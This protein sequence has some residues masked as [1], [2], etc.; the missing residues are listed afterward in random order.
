MEVESPQG[1]L[2]VM[3]KKTVRVLV[4]E[5]LKLAQLAAYTILSELGYEV[6]IAS[7]GVNAFQQI[8]EQQFDIIFIDIQLPDVDGFNIA[9]ILRTLERKSRTPLIAVTA[10]SNEQL[11]FD[12]KRH[13]FDDF[14]LKPLTVETVRY[15]LFKH[16]PPSKRNS[17]TI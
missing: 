1:E 2:G 13:G 12:T 6:S 17:E 5:D 8:M 10:N 7:N 15:M 3:A 16:L 14:M 11:P 9:E 4:I